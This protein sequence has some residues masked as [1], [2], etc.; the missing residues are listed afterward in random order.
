[1]MYKEFIMITLET[2]AGVE[3]RIFTLPDRPP[4]MVAQDLAEM[5]ETNARN[6]NRAVNRNP[7][8]FP[9]DFMFLLT[10]AETALFWEKWCQV[11][12]TSQGSRKDVGMRGFTHAGAN[13]LSAV[14]RTPVAAQVSVTVHRAFAAFEARAM[15]ETQM[16]LAQIRS[17]AIARKPSRYVAKRGVEQGYSFGQIKAMCSNSMTAPRLSRILREIKLLGLIE[18]LPRGMPEQF[19]LFPEA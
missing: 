6:I 3:A 7:D 5:Y 13:H 14:L 12:T 15:K 10:D 16:L 8:W 2:V 17:E 19:S 9:E 18:H 1:M 11:G 4:F